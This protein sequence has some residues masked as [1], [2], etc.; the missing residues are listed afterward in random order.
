MNKK[1]KYLLFVTIISVTLNS[2]SCK[3]RGLLIKNCTTDTLLIELMEF[4]TLND[5]IYWNHIGD[6]IILDPK[7]T[8]IVYIDGNKKILWNN[9]CVFPDSSV[10][11]TP[12]L[13]DYKDTC[14]IYTI[15]W[16]VVTHYTLEEIRDRKLYDRRPVTKKD[17]KRNRLFEYRK[18][19]ED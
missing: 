18:I 15:K 13:F 12:L 2:F 5:E 9:F 4:D 14:F 1:V 8:T 16:Q 6:S 10:C 11:V 17:F 3:S 19:T 7:D